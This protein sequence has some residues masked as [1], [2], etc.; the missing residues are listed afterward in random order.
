MGRTDDLF[1]TS[2]GLGRTTRAFI[3][4]MMEENM[5]WTTW[6]KENTDPERVS[7]KPEALADTVVVDLSYG[8]FAGLFASSLFSELGARVIRVEPPEGDI[9]RKMTPFGEFIHETGLPYLIEGRNKEHVTLNLEKTA[10]KK[11]LKSL[12]RK[13]DVLVETFTP[14]TMDEMELGWETLKTINPRLIYVAIN[15]Y[16]Q[17]GELSD[18]ARN[19][20]WKC[21]DIIAQALSGF[22]S[23]TGIPDSMEEFPEHTRVP[24]RM[25][26]WMG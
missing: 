7:G 16:G 23:T 1:G 17:T 8:S 15:S 12:V 3:Q 22:V 6:A 2:T 5:D 14:S 21:Y 24:T 9:A 13:A 11:I 4:G 10:G 19:A 18:K 20:K 25:G 26:N